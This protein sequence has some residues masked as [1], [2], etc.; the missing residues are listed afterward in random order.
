MNNDLVK[1]YKSFLTALIR[2]HVA[3][4]KIL[5]EEVM[6]FTKG[7]LKDCI[8]FFICAFERVHLEFFENFELKDPDS[9]FDY[10]I[11]PEKENEIFKLTKAG[12][13]LKDHLFSKL[14]KQSNMLCFN[15]LKIQEVAKLATNLRRFDQ[16]WLWLLTM[17]HQCS[18]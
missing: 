17:S 11:K 16:F 2:A 9:L 18:N 4:N 10:I 7:K 12:L 5:K 8:P 13:E 3:Q 6:F 14:E 15:G 1:G